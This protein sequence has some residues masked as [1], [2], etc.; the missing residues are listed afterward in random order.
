MFLPRAFTVRPRT[1][2]CKASSQPTPRPA[3]IPVLSKINKTNNDI[4]ALRA[5]LKTLHDNRPKHCMDVFYDQDEEIKEIL[6]ALKA[7]ACEYDPLEEYC[8]QE[9][10]AFECRIY[11]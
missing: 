1:T 4:I 3:T 9:P 8:E 5:E 6:G 2:S 7:K 11:E 10:S